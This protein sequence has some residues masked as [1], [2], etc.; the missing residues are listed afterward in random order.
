[1]ILLKRLRVDALKRLRAI[2]LSFARRGGVLIEGPNESGKSTLFEAIYFAL[3][4]RALVGE[5]SRPTLGA[6]IPHDGSQVRVSLVLISG[7]TELE[8][9]RSLSRARSGALTS[10]ASLVVR[11][12]GAPV[13]RISAVSA[14]TE[15]IEQELHGIDHDTFR[16][17]LFMEQKALER[18]EV[19]PRENRDKAI[20]RLLGL[21]RLT[22][23]ERLVAPPPELRARRDT[24]RA[25]LGVAER[26]HE[27]RAAGER[28]SEASL[29][30]RA[31]ELRA[32]I[33]QRDHL[34]VERETLAQREAALLAERD[35]LQAR[36]QEL[37]GIRALERRLVAADTL[38]WGAL[39]SQ[40][41]ADSLATRLASLAGAERLPEAQRRLDEISALEERLALA[42]D[43]QR[44]LTIAIEATRRVATCEEALAN[45]HHAAVQAERELALAVEALAR[46][47]LGETLAGWLHAR[48]AL[49]LQAD[50]D[51]RLAL[52][53]ADQDAQQVRVASARATA[54][55]WL[56]ISAGCGALAV[57]FVALALITGIGL[58]W[59]LVILGLAPGALAGLRWRGQMTTVRTR[60]WRAAEL[61]R[62][63]VALSA[64]VNLARRLGGA[65]LNQYEAGLRA[66]RVPTPTSAAEARARLAALPPP[67]SPAEVEA[68]ARAAQTAANRGRFVEERAAAELEM[69]RADLAQAQAQAGKVFSAVTSGQL[70]AAQREV[71][72]ITEQAERLDAP[73]D[74]P[75]LAAARGATEAVVATLTSSAADS[76]LVTARLGDQRERV[77]SARDE[78]AASL[79][80]IAT[81]ARAVGLDMPPDPDPDADIAELDALRDALSTLLADRIAEMDEPA[82]RAR[83][84]AV[85]AELDQLAA[86]RAEGTNAHARLAGSIS[87]ILEEMGVAARG[88]EPLEQL[89]ARWPPLAAAATLDAVEVEALRV[90]REHADREAYH[91]TQ[92]SEERAREARIE[93]ESLDVDAL[94]AELETVERELRQRELAARLAAETRGHIIRRALPETEA[95]MRAILPALTTGRYRDVSLA[96]DDAQAAQG[97]VDLAIRMWDDVAG[98]YV[99]KNLFS[100]GTRDQASLALRL[101]FALATLPR[102]RGATPGFIFLD[103]PLSA[104]DAERSRALALA[105]TRG[106]IAEAFPQIFLISHSQVIDPRDFDYTL[107]MDEGRAV[108]STLPSGDIAASLWDAE[109]G[110]R[111][112]IHNG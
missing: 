5:E 53:R 79:G 4:G 65:D 98:R 110:V 92:A 84:G 32:T 17:S 103:E 29:R 13:E 23:A 19:L 94:R 52:L 38:R 14:V 102:G 66:A 59:A 30:L 73:T 90:E 64:E 12:P 74:L 3:Y 34:A 78:W 11:R 54:R 16:N 106:A 101:A 50:G 105:L 46:Q 100:G 95:Y 108:E 82:L 8:V 57:F 80:D 10:E 71:A 83:E 60:A 69:A 42:L 61:D 36:L 75:G 70:E 62:Q 72:A 111:V 37:D 51:Q 67:Q 76:A 6:L 1:M 31:A 56:I 26:R 93:D 45:A 99:R 63:M 89:T 47:R 91:V 21:E 18:I 39:T 27:A 87:A 7:E 49:D 58:F 81:S 22:L 35:A 25:R 88:E 15:R 41:E 96:R 2:D 86:A 9:T 43:K 44:E 104:F 33:T 20:S 48:E 24:L 77:A 28:A 55:R 40:H 107:R 112:A 68:R 85:G 97:D 109:A